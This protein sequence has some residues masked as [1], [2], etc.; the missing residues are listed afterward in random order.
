[1]QYIEP[2]VQSFIFQRFL[3]KTQR[4]F[5]LD[6]INPPDCFVLASYYISAYGTKLDFKEATRLLLKSSQQRFKHWPSRAY[7]YRICKA[8]DFE[9][10]PD[11]DLIS[12]LYDSAMAGSRT[13]LADLEE[14]DEARYRS[15]KNIV[16]DCFAGVGASFFFEDN[17]LAG[18]TYWRWSKTF[19]NLEVLVQNLGRLNWIAEYKVNKRGDGIL[20]MAAASGKHLAI[21]TLLSSFKAL[22]INQINDQ[23]ETPLLCACRA[24][25]VETVYEILNHAADASISTPMGES[26]L[27]WLIS[28]GDTH[29]QEIAKGLLKAGANVRMC[30]RTRIAYSVFPSG[31]DVDREYPSTPLVWAV[32]NNRPRIVEV[33]LEE[34]QD[35]SIILGSLEDDPRCPPPLQLAACW[36]NIECLQLLV[37]AMNKAKMTFNYGPLL[38]KVIYGADPLSMIL[39][40][41]PKFKDKLFRTLDFLID[42]SKKI[43]MSFL[44]EEGDFRLSLLY[45]AITGAHDQ[46]VEHLLSP[47]VEELLG[48]FD[49]KSDLS[50]YLGAF[51][52]SDINRPCGSERRTPLL[53]SVRWNRIHMVEFLLQHGADPKAEARHPFAKDQINWTALHI[54]ANAGHNTDVSL[55]SL[56]VRSGLNIDGHVEEASENSLL[57]PSNQ[58]DETTVSSRHDLA[59][60][61][62]L[63]AVQNNA[64]NLATE[65][66]NLGADINALSLGSGFIALEH[67]TTVLGHLIAASSQHTV[68]RIRYL[69]QISNKHDEVDFVVEPA[70]NLSA[71]HRVSWAN[72]AVY[73]RSPEEPGDENISRDEYDMDVNRDILIEILQ[74][75]NDAEYLNR[76][77]GLDDKT[78]L[79]LAVEAGNVEA[80]R[81]L[82]DWGADRELEDA[83]GHN[84]LGYA[85]SRAVF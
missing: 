77:S 59:E 66:L 5:S 46:V 50:S 63:V 7:T 22:N 31:I 81:L 38:E 28:F 82:L 44:N 6:C 75:W 18:A 51:H 29:V 24:G 42:H 30:T 15:A 17:M 47:R 3:S 85:V 74:K 32:H 14:V 68:P 36:H 62:L 11:E 2:S 79:H 12:G 23:G 84:S 49:V 33:L 71:L 45:K 58:Q 56:L 54:L 40:S 69:L 78:A 76:R 27:H 16:H 60:T 53:E 19:D 70:R 80:V 43:Q 1:M 73:H 83:N 41:G 26:C 61:P 9:F 52:P 25:H 65:F 4:D 37:E 67:Q 20:H 13:A 21:K 48:P 34:T 57:E 35:A 64:F 8:L 39:R 10:K 55:A 72:K